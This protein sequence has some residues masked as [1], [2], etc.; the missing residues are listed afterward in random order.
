MTNAVL[1]DKQITQHQVN[2]LYLGYPGTIRLPLDAST[3]YVQGAARLWP[4]DCIDPHSC[5]HRSW[6]VRFGRSAA[7]IARAAQ[8]AAASP[9]R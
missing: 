6:H 3:S 9:A 5:S 4:L 1:V 7:R 8:N 2:K